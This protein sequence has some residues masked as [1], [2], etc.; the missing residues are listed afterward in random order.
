MHY[1]KVVPPALDLDAERR[2]RRS[3]SSLPAR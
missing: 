2:R 1:F 3:W